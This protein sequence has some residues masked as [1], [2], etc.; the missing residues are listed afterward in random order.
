VGG[1]TSRLR[2]RALV[3]DTDVMSSSDSSL[4]AEAVNDALAAW[5]K[6]IS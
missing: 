5:M 3:W 2:D 6:L 1:R 4:P